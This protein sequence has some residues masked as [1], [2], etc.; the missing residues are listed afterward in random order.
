MLEAVVSKQPFEAIRLLE[1]MTSLMMIGIALT[2]AGDPGA[3]HNGGFYLMGSMGLT[4]VVIIIIFSLAGFG[5]LSCLYANGRWPF[6]GPWCRVV[7]SF[8]GGFVWGQMGLS[9]ANW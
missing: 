2:I 6:Y 9:V 1:W 5:R 4:S 3:V 8:V 7:S